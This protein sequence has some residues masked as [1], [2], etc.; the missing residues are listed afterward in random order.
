M[1]A[2]I[3]PTFWKSL[4]ATSCIVHSLAV[5]TVGTLPLCF[6]SSILTHVSPSCFTSTIQSHVV[7]VVSTNLKIGSDRLVAQ[8]TVLITLRKLK[9]QHSSSYCISWEWKAGLT[10][11]MTGFWV[12]VAKLYTIPCFERMFSYLFSLLTEENFT[13]V[14]DL[15]YWHVLLDPNNCWSVVTCALSPGRLWEHTWIY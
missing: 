10:F 1:V 7:L 15:W 12:W 9:P 11:L 14:P 13:V 5:W 6:K 2:L 4:V 8:E 3:I